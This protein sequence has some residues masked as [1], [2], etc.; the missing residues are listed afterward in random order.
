MLSKHFEM[1]AKKSDNKMRVHFTTEVCF[2][3][4]IVSELYILLSG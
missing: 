4:L 3:S 1:C 2:I